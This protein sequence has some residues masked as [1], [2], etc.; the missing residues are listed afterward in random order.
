MVHSAEYETYQTTLAGTGITVVGWGFRRPRRS[1]IPVCGFGASRFA[2]IEFCKQLREMAGNPW[3]YA[4]LF[5]D[6]VVAF[7][8]FAGYVKVEEAMDKAKRE[9]KPFICAGFSGGTTAI[10]ATENQSWARKEVEAGKKAGSTR[11]KQ[12]ATLP[13]T[14][15]PAL[16]QQAALWNIAELATRK[17]NFGPVFVAS[18][19]DVSIGNYFDL[20]KIPYLHYGGINIVKENT[21]DDGGPGARVI[22]Q[23]RDQITELIAESE[24]LDVATGPPP[25]IMF[26]ALPKTELDP[27][28]DPA[29]HTDKEQTLMLFLVKTV[30][31]YATE[32]K[33]TKAKDWKTRN[34]AMCQA[35]EQTICKAIKL[36]HVGDPALDQTFKLNGAADQEVLQ[37]STDD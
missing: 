15:T 1:A 30:L 14:K 32:D 28:K 36:G 24:Y 16:V 11:G 27:T 31:P 34:I 7:T 37:I 23:G 19:E 3:D 18:G 12:A 4:W 17:L 6:N 33:R 9:G 22:Q 5:D 29:P 8:A 35:A 13:P 20:K 25:P 10:V 21:T 2:A 26:K